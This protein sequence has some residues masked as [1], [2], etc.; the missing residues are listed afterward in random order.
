MTSERSRSHHLGGGQSCG[1][2]PPVDETLCDETL[3]DEMHEDGVLVHR[4][5]KANP[6]HLPTHEDG[7][8]VPLASGTIAE[9]ATYRSLASA[10][11]EEPVPAMYRSLACMVEPLVRS[12]IPQTLPA[13]EPKLCSLDDTTLP[14]AVPAL[15]RSMAFDTGEPPVRS[16]IPQTLPASEPKLCSLDDT[17]LPSAVPVLYRSMAFETHFSGDPPAGACGPDVGEGDGM[18]LS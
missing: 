11:E 15:Y 10:V 5:L 9:P 8:A 14:S 12:T 13:S 4:S 18:E 3:F 6:S 1:A 16:T 17:T 2:G 7:A